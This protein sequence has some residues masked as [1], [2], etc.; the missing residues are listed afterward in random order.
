LF[1]HRSKLL[2]LS[3][4]A[5][6]LAL[7]ALAFPIAYWLRTHVLPQVFPGTFPGI[8]PFS[9]YLPFLAGMLGLWFAVGYVLGIYRKVELRSPQ[10]I[11]WDEVR[12]IFTA[13]ILVVAG[14]YLLRADVSRSL[15]LLFGVVDAVLVISGRLF[16]FYNKASLRRLLGKYHYFLIIGTGREAL[17]LAQ[18]IERAESLGLR[19]IGFVHPSAANA[20]VPPG[21][22]RRYPLH[23]LAEVTGILHNHVVDEV[24][25]AVEKQHLDRLEP[26][27]RECE[28]EG[29]KTRIHLSFLP[30]TT[31]KV[32]LDHIEHVPLLTLSTTP[33]DEMQLFAK[34]V[35]DTMLAAAAVVVL[36]P[37]LLVAALLVKLTSRGPVLYRQTRCGL[38]GRR[39]TLYKFRSMVDGAHQM[40][41]EIEHLNEVDGPVFKIADDPRCTPVGRW[42]RRT[43][44]DELPQLW[45]VL[46]G[47]MSFVGPRPPVPEEVDKYEPWQRRRLRMRPGLTCLWALEGRSKLNFERWMQLDLSYID[48]WSLWL[49]AKIFVKTI[50]HVLFGRG[51][52]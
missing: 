13:M 11:I 33:Q 28:R 2:G 35:L 14:L 51:A 9:W 1:E 52:W 18:L 39:F 46:R 45:N 32:S 43:S 22:A 30:A 5:H 47:D 41:A 36:S 17:E 49:D 29:V 24:L 4:L 25:V 16:L 37:I 19:L 42:L 10:Q 40:R 15:V 26:L 7:T 21:L 3:C 8:Y 6:D 12:L 31:S 27:L 20:V 50:P 23:S 38:G 34:R 48:R 44:L